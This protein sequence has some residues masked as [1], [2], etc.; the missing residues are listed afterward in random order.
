[1][2]SSVIRDLSAKIR[3]SFPE[4]EVYD[5][6]IQQNLKTPCF[7][8]HAVPTRRERLVGNN[9]AV[10]LTVRM[11]YIPSGDIQH[12]DRREEFLRVQSVLYADPE[13]RY[14]GTAY[15][16]NNLLASDND[17]VMYVTFNTS[18]HTHYEDRGEKMETHDTKI[19]EG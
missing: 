11:T 1:M 2:L 16:I 8:V 18:I 7:I 9:Y 19:N 10:W 14:L 4:C 17:Q 6:Q 13:W 12:T 15:H 5:S 3:L